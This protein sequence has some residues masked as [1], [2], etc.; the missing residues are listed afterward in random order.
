MAHGQMI[1]GETVTLLLANSSTGS[2]TGLPL[3]V[4]DANGSTRPIRA[5]ERLILDDVN[6]TTDGAYIAISSN[7]TG[8][9][10]LALTFS[11]GIANPLFLKEGA[12]CS[13]GSSAYVTSNGSNTSVW[14]QGRVINASMP[15]TQIGGAGAAGR[16]N[17]R[18]LTT[19]QGNF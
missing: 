6:G 16:P 1:Q 19:P 14:G 15:G 17:W 5:W 9:L 2:T 8:V 18:E 3:P 12:P 4:F 11:G 7:S 10:V 13:V